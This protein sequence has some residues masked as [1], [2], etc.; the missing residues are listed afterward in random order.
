M[1][2]EKRALLL[3]MLLGDGCLKTKPHKLGDGTMANYYEYVICHSVKQEDYLRHKLGLFHSIMGGK[4]PKVSYE[5]K[6][7]SS[8]RFSRCHKS[9]RLF[10]KYLYSNSGKKFFSKRVLNYLTP[11]AIAMWYMDD[12]C[13]TANRY[14]GVPTSY[15]M[16]I[17]TYFS[18]EEA[19][20]CIEYF[21]AKWNI[22]V[23]KRHYMKRGQFNLIF[24]TVESKKLEALIG[25]YI[26]ES[27]A[28]KLPSRLFT[29]APDPVTNPTGDDIV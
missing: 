29:R 19:D 6:E 11:H 12:G 18:E 17:Y 28:Y 3:G 10:K 7:H 8:C 2:K 1:N 5:I 4:E 23:K 25:Q 9:F 21:K 27:M 13:I 15:E 20:N 22:S 26:I 14:N 24:N 16:R